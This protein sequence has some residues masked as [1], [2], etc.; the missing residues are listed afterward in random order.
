MDKSLPSTK[1]RR[2][3]SARLDEIS[4]KTI[5]PALRRYGFAHAALTSCWNEIA[6]PTYARMSLPLKLGFP[7]SKKTGGTLTLAVDGA[8]AVELH[9]VQD[10][11]IEAVNRYFGYRA[12]ERLKLV[13]MPLPHPHRS[14]VRAAT[15]PEPPPELVAKMPETL[16]EGPLKAALYR[17][18]CTFSVDNPSQPCG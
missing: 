18:A 10:L 16:P 7:P 8:A 15:Q 9:Y 1:V 4:A 6:G 17:L 5:S 13:H 14:V 2:R 12:V 3:H 11:L